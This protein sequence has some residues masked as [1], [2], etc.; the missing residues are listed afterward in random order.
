[1]QKN[2][3]PGPRLPAILSLFLERRGIYGKIIFL[4][5]VYY[6]KRGSSQTFF[7]YVLYSKEKW[8]ISLDSV[9]YVGHRITFF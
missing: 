2:L 6:T 4:G 9:S 7:L 5:P 8:C 3:I 1:M